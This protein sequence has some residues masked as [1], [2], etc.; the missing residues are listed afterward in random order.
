MQVMVETGDVQVVGGKCS[1]RRQTRRVV[2]V[3]VKLRAPE[4]EAQPGWQ[5]VEIRHLAALVAVA[6]AGS[7]RRAADEL[8]YVQSAISSQ[9]AHLER[10]VG[11]RLFERSSGKSVVELT[12]AGRLLLHHA[13]EVLARLDSARTA[14]RTAPSANTR[15][16]RVTGL[17]LLGD[18][19]SAHV[20]SR[21]R[22]TNP[23]S[24][25]EPASLSDAG[26]ADQV[27]VF[28][29]E[30][31]APEL[32]D[33]TDAEVLDRSGYVLLVPADSA[34]ALA[35]AP[36]GAEELA[37]LQ[38]IVP[39]RH[40][41]KD[42]LG[43]QLA[44]LGVAPSRSPLAVSSAATAQALVAAGLGSAILLSHL[45]DGSD[46]R[47]ATVDLGH[48][49]EP[50]TVIVTI[51]NHARTAAAVNDFVGAL[52]AAVAAAADLHRVA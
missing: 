22:R 4:R 20:L 6:E 34:A 39:G 41:R 9:I 50:R 15:P 40:G 47:I 42:S 24:R 18:R 25:V 23:F 10:V 45:V 27:D 31:A 26:S 52:Y 17:E 29:R 8:E 16:I 37:A 21:F 32:T 1:G 7:F 43:R 30:A 19:L 14:L 48:L 35:R 38:P 46:P 49:L 28:L 51:A 12:D 2:S 13:E 44:A 33:M 11:M 5:T 3:D 36:I